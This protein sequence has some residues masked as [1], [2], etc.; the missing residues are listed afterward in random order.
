MRISRRIAVITARELKRFIAR[1]AMRA[2]ALREHRAAPSFR[3]L[4]AAEAEAI[5][6]GELLAALSGCAPPC[7]FHTRASHR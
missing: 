1:A 2:D 7:T 6:G 4:T 3:P 5:L